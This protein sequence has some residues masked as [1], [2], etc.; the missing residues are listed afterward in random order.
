MTTASGKN[1][2][3]ALENSTYHAAQ[4]SERLGKDEI[5]LVNL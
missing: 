4:V 2:E 1:P 3:A 5:I